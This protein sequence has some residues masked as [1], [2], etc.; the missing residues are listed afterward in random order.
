MTHNITNRD[1]V[2][3]VRDAGWHGLA[4]VFD[5]YPTREQAQ[6]VAHPW[7]PIPEPLFRRVPVIIDGQPVEQYEEVEGRVAIVRD[8][9]NEVIGTA[10]DG[11]GDAIVKNSTMYDIAEAVQ[12][13]APKDVKFETG[14]SLL[15]GRKVWLLLRLDEPLL[16]KGDPNGTTIPY[17]A[18]QNSHDGSG[19]FRG[20][21]TMT[22]IICDNTSKMADLDA[23]A[24][25][26]EFVFRHTSSIHDRVE[27][28]KAALAGWRDSIVAWQRLQLH[29]LDI[30]VTPKQRQLFVDEFVPMPVKGL[31]S[32][33]VVTN[34]NEARKAILDILAGPTCDG[35]NGTAYGLVQAATEYGQHVRRAN[36]A[37][38]RFKRAYLD[39]D[40]LTAD[41]LVLAQEVATV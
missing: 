30:P 3:S 34:I 41:A 27:E 21:C 16:V 39:R 35:I 31:I 33:R 14:G 23:E 29:L 8:D 26:T 20:Q 11:V 2:F 15:G 25:G 18:L 19:A 1:G 5:D 6:A 9:T 12:G 10:S 22:R 17:Y 4:T 28:A 36:T 13:G 37:E 40:R 38:T 24:R 32:D 7:E